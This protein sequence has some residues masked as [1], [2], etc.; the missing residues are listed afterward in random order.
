MS[1]YTTNMIPLERTYVVSLLLK[2]FL[3]SLYLQEPFYIRAHVMCLNALSFPP[4]P[5]C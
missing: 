5:S 3:T 4:S 1:G 2:L